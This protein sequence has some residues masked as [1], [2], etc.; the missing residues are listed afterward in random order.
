MFCQRFAYAVLHCA[1]NYHFSNE[2]KV[3]ASWFFFVLESLIKWTNFLELWVIISIGFLRSKMSTNVK[4]VDKQSPAPDQTHYEPRFFFAKLPDN[5]ENMQ[6]LD[7]EFQSVWKSFK[8]SFE[9]FPVKNV[10]KIHTI[11]I[12]IMR[13]FDWF[14]NTVKE[15][16]TGKFCFCKNLGK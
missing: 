6:K 11:W 8:V 13:H 2:N 5:P 10:L 1:F 12:L 16:E 3:W 14:S 7:F 9:Y 4:R 15:E